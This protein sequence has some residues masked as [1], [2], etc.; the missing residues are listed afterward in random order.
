MIKSF[1]L[2]YKMYFYI[3]LSV[4]LFSAGWAVNGWRLNSRIDKMK[5]EQQKALFETQRIARELVVR[6]EDYTHEELTKIRKERDAI[7]SQL[8]KLRGTTISGNVVS[9][10][11]DYTGATGSAESTQ[12]DTG[13]ADTT[14]N[15]E[16]QTGII[17]D[18]YS[19]YKECRQQVISWNQF[20]DSLLKEFNR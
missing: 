10:L 3:G 17:I 15:A 9:V 18:N 12:N 16:E 4:F 19:K 14:Y 8:K 6:T 2:Q 7:Q 1:L 20:Y 11:S 5:I 13:T